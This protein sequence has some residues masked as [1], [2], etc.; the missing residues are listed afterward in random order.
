MNKS[1][2]HN[3][4]VASCSYMFNLS[5]LIS[6]MSKASRSS[7]ITQ[8]LLRLPLKPLKTKMFANKLLVLPLKTMHIHLILW[9]LVNKWIKGVD[10]LYKYLKWLVVKI[11]WL[12]FWHVHIPPCLPDW[13]IIEILP[14]RSCAFWFMWI[15]MVKVRMREWHHHMECP[16]ESAHFWESGSDV[17]ISLCW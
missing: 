16:K 15:L 5:S 9:N 8:Q 11:L 1:L 4:I 7:I 3:L 17:S 10:I 12:L 14:K 13:L 6:K 2:Q